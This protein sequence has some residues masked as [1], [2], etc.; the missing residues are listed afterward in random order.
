MKSSCLLEIQNRYEKLTPTERR[1]ADYIRANGPDV[2]HMSVQEV[3][4]QTGAAKSAV[5]RCCKALGFD[6]FPALKISLSADL[7]KN[8]QMNF[9]INRILHTI[10]FTE[11]ALLK[12]Q[13][14]LCKL[15]EDIPL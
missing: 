8:S 6:G 11:S 9:I 1:I 7:S 2:V 10:L 5:L 14:K 4:E 12:M 13:K 15:K 3:A